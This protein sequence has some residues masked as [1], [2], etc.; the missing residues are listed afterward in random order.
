MNEVGNAGRSQLLRGFGIARNDHW[1]RAPESLQLRAQDPWPAPDIPD[2]SCRARSGRHRA[3]AIS[4]T[5]ENRWVTISKPAQA[6]KLAAKL[7]RAD[8]I[9]TSPI[10]ASRTRGSF[11]GPS[12]MALGAQTKLF[13]TLCAAPLARETDRFDAI[14]SFLGRIGVLIGPGKHAAARAT[15]AFSLSAS[16]CSQGCGDLSIGYRLPDSRQLTRSAASP[17]NLREQGNR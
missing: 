16:D 17:S 12:R 4:S 8:R 7:E 1:S 2:R 9:F 5:L 14:Q 6:K 15:T 3:A 13:V 10:S 11:A